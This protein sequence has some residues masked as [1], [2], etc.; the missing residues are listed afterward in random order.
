MPKSSLI[1]SK[2][3]SLPNLHDGQPANSLP[4]SAKLSTFAEQP[5]GVG[6]GDGLLS[7][8]ADSIVHLSGLQGDNG[9]TAVFGK[10]AST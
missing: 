9:S 6:T 4:Y 10:T 8:D 5:A 2:T 7:F 3:A 1:S